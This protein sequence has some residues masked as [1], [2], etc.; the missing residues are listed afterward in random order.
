MSTGKRG[1]LGPRLRARKGALLPPPSPTWGRWAKS[2]S[3]SGA[4]WGISHSRATGPSRLSVWEE[5]ALL[6]TLSKTDRKEP[7]SFFQ[8]KRNSPGPPPCPGS[9]VPRWGCWGLSQ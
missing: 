9:P 7:L 3:P 1:H 6:G 4:L 2:H 5:T 8:G